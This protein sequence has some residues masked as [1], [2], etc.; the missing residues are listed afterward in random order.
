[1][2]RRV[3]KFA[4]SNYSLIKKAISLIIKIYPF[5][6]EISFFNIKNENQ[7][8]VISE[9]IF[10]NIIKN[11]NEVFVTKMLRFA[12]IIKFKNEYLI[13]KKKKIIKSLIDF[14]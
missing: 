8:L 7:V 10:A 12:H 14:T 2:N 9:I 3:I 13:N 11:N 6:K 4:C 5:I 1:M